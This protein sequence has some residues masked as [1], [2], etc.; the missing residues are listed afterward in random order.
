MVVGLQLLVGAVALTMS[1]ADSARVAGT[2]S[3]DSTRAGAPAG[4]PAAAPVAAAR[5]SVVLDE[6]RRL[7]AAQLA[8]QSL[9]L[10]AKK[11]ERPAL[12]PKAPGLQMASTRFRHP[13]ELA[14]RD[15]R[16]LISSS[17]V[18]TEPW[19][20]AAPKYRKRING[21]LVAD[22]IVVVKSTHRMTLFYRGDSVAVFL[23]ALG[24]SPTGNKTERGDNRT[25]EGLYYI[26]ARNPQSEYYRSLHVS[27]PSV[28]ER[29]RALKLGLDPGG[30]IMIHGLPSRFAQVG[31][32]H[33]LY[34]WT[35]G[36]IAVTNQEMDEIFD[37][38]Q[39]GA[40]IDIKP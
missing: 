3:S 13:G 22:S 38:V 18:L 33:R 10:A 34:D 32:A 16:R 40:V 15:S 27:Y 1:G 7:L 35:K 30:D 12:G 39:L 23:V 19:L 37:A 2:A 17:P 24:K 28:A 14:T 5:D 25:P 11:S 29:E 21:R 36:C 6:T 8:G 20:A 4:A 9:G 26:D 31:D